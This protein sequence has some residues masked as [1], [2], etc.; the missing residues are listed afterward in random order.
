TRF[1][2]LIEQREAA[3]RKLLQS[4]SA[5]RHGKSP[6]ASSRPGDQLISAPQ[7]GAKAEREHAEFIPLANGRSESEAQS[8]LSAHFAAVSAAA[9][10]TEVVT[11]ALP[12]DSAGVPA[13][14]VPAD[15]ANPH[16]GVVAFAPGTAPSAVSAAVPIVG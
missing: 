3:A 2:A 12:S 13:A 11:A 6:R 10:R 5:S 8:G 1:A 9:L 4:D 15:V 7:K 16:A 14:G